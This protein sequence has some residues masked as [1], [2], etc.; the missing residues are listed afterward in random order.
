MRQISENIRELLERDFVTTK[1]TVS[2]TIPA[3]TGT[4]SYPETT[5]YY[6]NGEG[7]VVD[8][9]SYT[10]KL[11]E[12]GTIRFSLGAAPDNTEITLENVSRDLGFILTDTE[13][14]IDGSEVT[15][16]KIYKLDDNTWEPLTLFVGQVTDVV[17]DHEKIKL[18]LVSDMSK[19][20]TNVGNTSATQRCILVFNANGSGVGE[21][22]GWK[23]SMPGNASTCDHT[24][25]GDNG[26]RA[27]GNLARIGAV[28]AF[29]AIGSIGSG[30]S[31]GGTGYD[32]N[33]G[34]WVSGNCV[35]PDAFVLC[36]D[37]EGKRLWTKAYQLKDTS[38]LVS[39]DEFGELTTTTL[40]TSSKGTTTTLYTV[41]TENG[42]SISC[43]PSHP[44]ITSLEDTLGTPCYKLQVEDSILSLD[45]FG[46]KIEEDKIVSIEK[47]EHSCNVILL[48]LEEP[49]HIYVGGNTV[50]GGILFHNMKPKFTDPL[51]TD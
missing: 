11:R 27:H 13:R 51:L 39:I 38:T 30:S 1:Y 47:I 3:T 29:T 12:V 8:G 20:G 2:L 19:R 6:A 37:D 28:P 22:C 50:D 41:V 5:L 31:G 10:D 35:Y 49:R 25:D 42:Y 46:Q 21:E 43:S 34:G 44:F 26:C 18:T 14:V 48:Q 17:I 15:I 7:I 40:I 4:P 33:S 16:K 24:V 9:V 32:D 36:L 23:T 45:F